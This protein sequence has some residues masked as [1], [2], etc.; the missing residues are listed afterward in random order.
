VG[1]DM[2]IVNNQSLSKLAIYVMNYD[3][4]PANFALTAYVIQW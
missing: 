2:L 3:K 4:K 1:S